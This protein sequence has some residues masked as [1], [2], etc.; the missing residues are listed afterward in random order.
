MT[1]STGPI[2]STGAGRRSR[3]Q[4]R[5]LTGLL[6]QPRDPWI[7]VGLTALVAIAMTIGRR[8]ESITHAQFWAEDGAQWFADAYNLGW[9]TSTVL[10]NAGYYDTIARLTADI[11]QLVDFRHA[12]LVF[13]GVALLIQV[14]P[15][16]FFVTPR[17]EGVVPDFRLRLFLALL[18]IA[19]PNSYELD[20]NITNAHTH[21]SLLAALIILATPSPRLGWTVFDVFGLVLSGLSGPFVIALA[22]VAV[23]R[24]F[25]DRE[26]GWRLTL[27]MLVVA[28]AAI[29]AFSVL[30]TGATTRP[31]PPLGATPH[32]FMAVIA[33]NVFSGAEV[34]LK[35]YTK[36]FHLAWWEPHSL[37]LRISFFVGIGAV[38]YAAIRGPIEL[39]LFTLFAWLVL[40]ASMLTPVLTLTG[41]QWPLL[42]HP[43]AGNRYYLLP[44]LSF[45]ASIVWIALKPGPLLLR[46]PAA[47]LV[48]ATLLVGVPADWRYP[49]YADYDPAHYASVL[50]STPPGGRVVIPINPPGWHIKLT[51]K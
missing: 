48:V 9:L 4:V 6:R 23:L 38:V 33:G 22:P 12:A 15:A 31:H 39:R 8:P 47:A 10:P 34:G 44:M 29:Q 11:S 19:I 2:G 28:G 45:L 40:L 21:M 5:S 27:M 51:K 37:A 50:D 16:L 20:A 26:S 35:N 36:L 3:A 32:S 43:G 1:T 7:W 42:S 41:D 25:T 14:L 18:Y 24:W 30:G 13:N 17:F 49:R 46:A